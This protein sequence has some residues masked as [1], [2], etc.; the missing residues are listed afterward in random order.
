MVDRIR[1]RSPS[2]D[3]GNNF[4]DTCIGTMQVRE[5][6]RMQQRFTHK[7]DENRLASSIPGVAWL[8]VNP[9]TGDVS[10]Y[11]KAVVA[12]IEVAHRLG[13]TSVPLAGTRGDFEGAIVQFSDGSD[14]GTPIQ[15]TWGGDVCD[16]RRVEVQRGD[17]EIVVHV[18]HVGNAYHLSDVAVPG[19]SEERRLPMSRI[20][21]ARPQS[22]KLPP[23]NPYREPVCFLNLGADWPA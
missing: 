11:P 13:R 21:L 20:D 14:R 1:L 7:L 19:N 5:A 17:A 4:E 12:R 8:F 18:V 22:P 2:P 9:L 6:T 15:K 3:T 16:V 10:S 23:V